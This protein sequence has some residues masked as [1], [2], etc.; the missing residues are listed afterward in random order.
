MERDGRLFLLLIAALAASGCGDDQVASGTPALDTLEATPTYAVV[1]T[2]FSSTSIAMLDEQFDIIH[3]SWLNSGTTYPGL[4]AALSGDVVLPTRQAGDG[5]FSVID[6]YLTD[7]VTRFFVPSGHLNGQLRTQGA[8]GETG[9]SSNPQ[10][11]IFVHAD[12]A[13]VPRYDPNL[14]PDAL[15]ENRG[16]DLYEIDPSDMSP[17]GRRIDVSSLNTT[18][19]VEG[20]EVEVF[21]RPSRGV[22][23]GSTIVLGLDRISASFDAAGPG[24]VAL[25][26]LDDQSVVRLALPG[27]ASCGRVVPIPEEP[28][29]A[30]V[31]CTGFS[32]PFGDETQIRASAGIAVI[33]VQPTGATVEKVWRATDDS[34]SAI[35]VN[36]LVALD[37]TRVLAVSNGNFADS[38]DSLFAID[39]D[40]G[41]QQ[42]VLTSAGSY[43]IGT[44]AYDSD[45]AML[46]VPD[47][48]ANAVIELAEDEGAFVEIGRTSIAPS[49]GLPPAQVYL[50]R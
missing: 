13:W 37:A 1:S 14:D 45:R 7:V 15:A 35:A 9:F 39:L 29:R 8:T 24:A 12:S 6:R 42:P 43:T 47:A 25:V 3:E 48:A 36:A 10:D 38:T 16:N 22:L 4:V 28:T 30:A 49:L 2:D 5:T 11:L 46:Y 40:S 34:A 31:A 27:L 44:S 50:L 17:T 19:I 18:V 20:A 23:I 41:A 33:D 32:Y 21:A 26:H